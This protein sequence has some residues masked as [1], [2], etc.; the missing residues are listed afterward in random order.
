M[1]Y[2]VHGILQARILSV[3]IPFSRGCSQPR[4]QTQVSCM[5]GGFFTSWA[6]RK[7]LNRMKFKRKDSKS[8]D[9]GEWG[10]K[11]MQRWSKESGTNLSLERAGMGG[12]TSTWQAWKWKEVSM[13][14]K[15]TQKSS[16]Q[17]V[18]HEWMNNWMKKMNWKQATQKKIHKV[19]KYW[20][21]AVSGLNGRQSHW[22][23]QFHLDGNEGGRNLFIK[24]RGNTSTDSFS[25]LCKYNKSYR[26]GGR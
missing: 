16:A 12:R 21:R 11:K 10:I 8:G 24:M 25:S 19:S 13:H 4:D 9:N 1:D 18:F 3:A 14:D 26:K 5:A 2:T 7:A 22:E 15:D 23:W 20:N 17:L 6:T